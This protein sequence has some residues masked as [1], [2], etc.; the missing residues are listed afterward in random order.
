MKK[1]DKIRKDIAKKV[2]GVEKDLKKKAKGA[3]KDLS[4]KAKGAK[5]DLSK[6]AKGVEKDLKEGLDKLTPGKK[7][8]GKGKKVAA[9][10]AAGLAAAG[11]IGVV[12]ARS[13]R[14]GKTLSFRVV[15]NEEGWAV[16]L[17]D[18]DEPL[19]VFSRKRPA[20]T[21]GRKAARDAA[22][23]RLDIHGQDG[24]ILKSHSYED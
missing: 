7:G 22:P 8:G 3:K 23:S 2:K 24:R 12:A 6:K 4:K 19:G 14:S 11:A 9:A 13:R 17:D 5:K 10:A 21:A 18:R 1:P 15:P 16:L 20:V